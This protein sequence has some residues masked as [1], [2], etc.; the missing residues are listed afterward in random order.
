MAKFQFYLYRSPFLRTAF[1]YRRLP[2]AVSIPSYKLKK[3]NDNDGKI[4]YNKSVLC[5][6]ST[7]LTNKDVF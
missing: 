2:V 3:D 1:F 6:V 7:K 4:S 5:S